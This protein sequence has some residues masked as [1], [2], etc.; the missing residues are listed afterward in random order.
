MKW[1]DDPNSRGNKIIILVLRLAILA[2]AVNLAIAYAHKPGQMVTDIGQSAYLLA[3]WLLACL[4]GEAK[5]PE[6]RLSM[7]YI[8]IFTAIT[9]VG[10][11]IKI[12]SL[13]IQRG[14][15]AN[16]VE[17]SF[18]LLLTGILLVVILVAYAA[19]RRMGIDREQ[20]SEDPSGEDEDRSD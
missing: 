11:V 2:I 15:V 20:D 16:G 3:F 12:H 18:Q 4:N 1:Y 6:I 10:L 19:R 8:T 14:D 7:R 17:H 5:R 13:W 9:T